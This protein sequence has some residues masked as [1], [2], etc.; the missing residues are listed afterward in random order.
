MQNIVL[1]DRTGEI[2]AN[3][4]HSAALALNEQAS[5]HVGSVWQG[6]AASVSVAPSLAAVPV[7][8]WPVFLVKKLPPGEGGFH[9]DKHNQPFAKV[10][11]SAGDESWTIDASHEICEMLVDP[12]GNRMQASEAIVI[13][14]DGV[15]DASGTYQY[16]VE[17]CDPCEAN[18][19]AYQIGG[20]ALSDFITPAFYDASLTPG[21]L[22]SY[23]GNI[24]RPRGMLPGGYISY[25]KPD[26]SWEQIL[27]VDPNSPP[28]YNELGN[29]ARLLG[30]GGKSLR[31]AVHT[32]MGPE[33]DAQKHA[34]RRGA[35]HNSAA[36]RAAMGRHAPARAA[37]LQDW[38]GLDAEESGAIILGN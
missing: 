20:I 4:L 36:V 17:A 8:A 30:H 31:E 27:W 24:T 34:A 23:K 29:A 22:Y 13:S 33:R 38:Y 1:V 14:G 19:Y 32:A 26:G 12:Y 10:I 25:V 11:A 9:S 21:R 18:A 6:V 7:G 3:L 5:Q 15:A 2:D 35:G 28:Q 16:L 37:N